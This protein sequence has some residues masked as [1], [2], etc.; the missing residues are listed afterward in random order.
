MPGFYDNIQC[1]KLM[2][3]QTC[4]LFKLFRGPEGKKK[5]GAIFN[6]ETGKCFAPQHSKATGLKCPNFSPESTI[7]DIPYSKTLVRGGK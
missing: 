6:H 5:C 4:S 2:P 1:Q 7:P 3:G